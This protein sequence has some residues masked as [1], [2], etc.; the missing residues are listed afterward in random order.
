[1]SSFTA[2][3]DV[4]GRTGALPGNQQ[5]A[6]RGSCRE[7]NTK[8]PA[9]S[10]IR[11][12]GLKGIKFFSN[13]VADGSSRDSRRFPGLIEFSPGPRLGRSNH[14]ITDAF[15]RPV[16]CAAGKRNAAASWTWRRIGRGRRDHTTP[17]GG[18]RRP[19]IAWCRR[20]EK[21]EKEKGRKGKKTGHPGER[22]W[23]LLP[24]RAGESPATF[25]GHRG[26]VRR[27]VWAVLA[28]HRR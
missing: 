17:R 19:A 9:P 26:P 14:A 18:P 23:G 6:T 28:K 13:M 20:K 2:S 12:L 4:A 21:K 22:W 16:D 25:P 8:R 15:G 11:Y 10:Q 24:S 1:V 27:M 7:E 3:I 5:G